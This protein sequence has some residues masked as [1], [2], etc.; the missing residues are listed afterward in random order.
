MRYFR[1][2]EKE[3]LM[4]K[5]FILVSVAIMFSGS[6]FIMGYH[7]YLL[8]LY[9]VLAFGLACTKQGGHK[10]YVILKPAFL[11]P[12][13]LFLLFD[14]FLVSQLLYAYVPS[15]VVTYIIRFAIMALFLV[16]VPRISVWVYL[17][18]LAKYYSLPVAV[19]ILI[20]TGLGGEKSGGLVGN[21]QYAGMLM[22][23]AGIL[24]M[25]D[26]FENRENRINILGLFFSLAALM[27]SGKRMFAL[28]YVFAFVV[29]FAISEN[30]K[31]YRK[32]LLGAVGA[33]IAV[34]VI[35]SAVPAAQELFYRIVSRSGNLQMAT[36]GRNVLWEKAL[37]L[38]RENRVHGIGFGAFQTYFGNTYS[39]SGI[40]AFLT[41]NIYVGLLAETGSIGFA[42]VVLFLLYNLHCTVRLRKSVKYMGDSEM[43]YVWKYSVLIQLWFIIYGFTGNG[44][45]DVTEMFLYLTGVAMMLTLRCEFRRLR[46]TGDK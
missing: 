27:T 42:L 40:Q 22:S 17:L 26:Y 46:L 23:V 36:S 18:K 15:I 19:S 4:T 21:H 8:V 7:R 1:Q 10:G 43:F 35:I 5:L 41:H 33:G 24:F 45:Y 6:T 38:Y 12:F 34:V 29:I 16:F 32:F 20:S 13:F 14:A 11:K 25:I 9:V 39:I 37:I 28:L 3:N 44:I 2:F 31:K 30:R